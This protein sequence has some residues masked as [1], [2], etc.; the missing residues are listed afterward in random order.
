MTTYGLLKQWRLWGDTTFWRWSFFCLVVADLGRR[1]NSN[2]LLGAAWVIV[3]VLLVR[4][5]IWKYRTWQCNR[6][7][8]AADLREWL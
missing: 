8:R 1:Y 6:V 4:G 2:L 5:G 3:V 7:T